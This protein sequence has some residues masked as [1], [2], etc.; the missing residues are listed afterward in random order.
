MKV[1]IPT[2]WTAKEARAVYEFLEHMR[3][4]IFLVYQ[5]DIE[6]MCWHECWE[7][8]QN[9]QAEDDLTANDDP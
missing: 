9:L 8:S 4:K 3:D 2:H 7:E 5:E 6:E 1:T